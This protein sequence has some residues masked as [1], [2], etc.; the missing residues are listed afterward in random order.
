MERERIT[1]HLIALLRCVSNLGAII[2]VKYE[3]S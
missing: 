3:N 1:L 2:Q